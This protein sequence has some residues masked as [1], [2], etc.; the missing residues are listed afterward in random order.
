MRYRDSQLA[1]V[2]VYTRSGRHLGRLVGFV[3]ESDTHEVIQY[4]V[5]KSGTFE[6]LL[7]KEFLVNRSQVISVSEEKMVVD[8]ATVAE[9][10]D[11]RKKK[12]AAEPAPKTVGVTRSME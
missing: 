8:D 5:K 11:A 7:P 6:L 4:A 1:G 9:K 10:A 12:Q 3:V 2:P